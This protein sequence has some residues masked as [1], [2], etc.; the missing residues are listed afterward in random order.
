VRA[1]Q[2]ETGPSLNLPPRAHS[3]T[4]VPATDQTDA[5]L[6]R[7]SKTPKTGTKPSAAGPSRKRAGGR[8]LTPAQRSK[9]ALAQQA[10][11]AEVMR[12]MAASRTD[13]QPVL[14]AVTRLAAELC[15]AP[16]ALVSLVEGTTLI[17]RASY[18]ARRSR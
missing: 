18:P 10:A 2:E 17:A 12:V 1:G 15:R 3:P 7:E 5:R 9:E 13:V 16:F 14:D 6:D 8:A 11:T 4:F